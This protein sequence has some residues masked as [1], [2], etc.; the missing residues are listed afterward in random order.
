MTAT[1][2]RG[3]DAI[4][5]DFY[6]TLIHHRNDRG[7]GRNLVEYLQAESLDP[8]PW[9]HRMLYDVFDRHDTDYAPDLPEDRKRRYLHYLASRVFEC[10]NIDVGDDAIEVH[11]PSLW[12]ILGPEAFALFPE[13]RTVLAALRAEGYP[14]ALVSNWQCGLGN[15]VVELDLADAFDHVISSAE[16]GVAKPDHRIFEEACGRLGV[17]PDRVLHVGDT[18]ID[19]YEG[20]S[21]AG[22]HAVLLHRGPDPAPDGVDTIPDLRQLLSRLPTS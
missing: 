10:L 3:I 11:A 22:L 21:E 20:G 2:D 19:D 1:L 9:E 5:L 16:L 17:S 12:R 14:I 13:T 4:T 7:R 15:F 18:L 6:G 8:A